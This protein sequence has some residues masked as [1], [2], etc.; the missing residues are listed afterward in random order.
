MTPAQ[1]DAARALAKHPCFVPK[2]GMTGVR[3]AP[4]KADN[5][6]PELVVW[7]A[8]SEEDFLAFGCMPDLADPA[9]VGALEALA[10]ELTGKPELSLERDGDQWFII[11][12]ACLYRVGTGGTYPNGPT[13]G[14]AWG[15][16]I[17]SLPCPK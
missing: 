5:L 7:G 4:G 12:N 11:D 6:R 13:R 17:L 9:T 15:A 3:N 16:L 8:G 1:Q 14:E 2:R 10:C